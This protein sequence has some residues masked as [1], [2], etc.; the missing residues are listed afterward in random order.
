MFCRRVESQVHTQMLHEGYW[1]ECKLK[2]INT[3]VTSNHS[4]QR[5]II[6]DKDY[7]ITRQISNHYVYICTELMN[8]FFSSCHS[9]E[10]SLHSSMLSYVTL[11]VLS[12]FY[13]ILLLYALS[14][15][16]LLSSVHT[17]DPPSARQL[18][19]EAYGDR[20]EHSVPPLF[21]FYRYFQ[22]CPDIFSSVLPC[23][24]VVMQ[25]QEM[26]VPMKS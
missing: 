8:A 11:Y 22:N 3:V 5:Q 15:I 14:K 7:L 17:F 10:P 9:L 25:T 26:G 24:L 23:E 12:F 20:C 2:A 6:F 18:H 4:V 1:V 16:I 21:F 13:M 19:L